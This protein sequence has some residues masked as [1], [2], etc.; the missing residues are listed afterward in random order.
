MSK[1]FR[2]LSVEDDDD[3]FTLLKLALKELPLE[4][5]RARSGGDAVSILPDFKPELLILDVNLPDI[6]GWQVLD[7]LKA[8]QAALVGAPVIVLTAHTEASHRVIGKLQDVAH[9]M[10]KPFVPASLCAKV[11]ELLKIA[12]G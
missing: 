12:D 7:W 10:N 5:R 4:L 3:Q 2:T 6:G 9:Y 1:V 8:N 11:K